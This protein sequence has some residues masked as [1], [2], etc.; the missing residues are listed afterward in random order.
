MIEP[1]RSLLNVIALPILALA[2]TSCAPIPY[3]IDERLPFT[4]V[5]SLKSRYGSKPA[6]SIT[7]DEQSKV[8]KVIKAEHDPLRKVLGDRIGFSFPIGATFSAYLQQAQQV[9]DLYPATERAR[10]FTATIESVDLYYSVNTPRSTQPYIDW[11]SLTLAIT[12][13]EGGKV[14]RRIT[15]NR[16]ISLKGVEI[17]YAFDRALRITLG[18]M[19]LDYLDDVIKQTEKSGR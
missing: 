7:V 10:P 3:Q 13:T 12:T 18:E 9:A 14:I 8:L 15:L 4:I 1:C 11:V 19:V 2:L 6:I 17:T 16:E 5:Q